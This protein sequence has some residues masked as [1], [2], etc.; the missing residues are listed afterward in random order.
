MGVRE[1]IGASLTEIRTRGQRLVELNVELVKAELKKKAQEYGGAIG[2]LVAGALLALYALG[3]LLATIT[4]ALALV[5]PLWLSLLIVTLALFLTVAILMLAGRNRLQKL[6][7]APPPQAAAEARITATTA[8]DGARR[9]AKSL[10][11]TKPSAP[12]TVATVAHGAS[13]SP[14]AETAE[15]PQAPPNEAGS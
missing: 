15:R 14:A 12:E 7:V 1:R 6:Q 8:K 9:A 2:M 11:P 13:E 5:L 4:V 3:F 10:R